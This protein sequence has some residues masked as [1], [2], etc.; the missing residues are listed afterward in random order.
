M[1]YKKVDQ[2]VINDMV[3]KGVLVPGEFVVTENYLTVPAKQEKKVYNYLYRNG[4]GSTAE[5]HCYKG[6]TQ[7]WTFYINED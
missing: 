7:Q 4:Y 5:G 1:L 6:K 3:N 2:T